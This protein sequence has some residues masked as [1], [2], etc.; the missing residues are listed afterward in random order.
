MNIIER[1]FAK[2]AK[3]I[4]LDEVNCTIVGLQPDAVEY[5]VNEYAIKTENYYHNVAYQLGKWDGRIRFF[6]DTSKTY[7]YLL[8]KIIPAIE[9]FGYKMELEDRWG[10]NYLSWNRGWKNPD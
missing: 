7:V 8:P 3:I 4:V 1:T 2:K 5:F 6:S 9:A 10:W